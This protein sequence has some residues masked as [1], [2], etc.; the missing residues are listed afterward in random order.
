MTKA[1]PDTDPLLRE[2]R[3]ARRL[4]R[5]F[6]IERRGG[7]AR[8][9]APTL[10]RLT[11]RRARLIEALAELERARRAAHPA[12][13]P[14]LDPALAG[15]A[16]EVSRSLPLATGQVEALRAELE[17]WHGGTSGLRDSSGNRLLGRG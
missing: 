13:S 1:D 4:E 15:L 6:R 8:L 17:Q 5:L 3:I 11:E 16:E 12:R 9:P 2:S 10:H 14:A 7:F